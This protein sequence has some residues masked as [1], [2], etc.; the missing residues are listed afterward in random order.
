MDDGVALRRFVDAQE[1]VYDRVLGEL[2]TGR[3][4]THWMWFIF[5][6]IA[7]L[8]HSA[9]SVRFAISSLPEAAAYL[10]HPLLGPRLRECSALM[11]EIE[12]RSIEA[13]LG[14]PD[15]DKFHSSMT[16]F[17]QA[18]PEEPVFPACLEKYFAG[19]PDP[20]TLARL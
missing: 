6:Q 4:R 11:L 16:L 5:P 12:G 17:A 9:T 1:P 8:G 18:G 20:H 14:H 13:I 2:R 3:K 7:G 19:E 15:D 10:A